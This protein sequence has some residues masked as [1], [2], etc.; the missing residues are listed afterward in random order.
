MG[1]RQKGHRV[2][3]EGARGRSRWPHIHT[4]WVTIRRDALGASRPRP[5]PDSTAESQCREDTASYF[6]L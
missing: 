3:L 4:W 6:W 1:T 2:A 5:R